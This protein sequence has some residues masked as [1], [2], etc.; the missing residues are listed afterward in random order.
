MKCPRCGTVVSFGLTLGGCLCDLKHEA[1]APPPPV[2]QHAPDE[3]DTPPVR[4]AVF[5]TNAGTPAVR[6]GVPFVDSQD[7]VVFFRQPRRH[8][9]ESVEPVLPICDNVPD[10]LTWM[11]QAAVT[12]A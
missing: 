4:Q 5:R 8:L 2:N 7:P 3:T 6:N 10:D 1:T 12:R 9:S 11:S